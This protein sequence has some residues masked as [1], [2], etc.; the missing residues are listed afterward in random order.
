VRP[1]TDFAKEALFNVLNNLIGF[2]SVRVLDLFTGTGSIS[3][4]FVSR[5]CPSVTAVDRDPRCIGFINKVSLEFGIENLRTVRSDVFQILR[6]PAASF[7]LIFADPPY[8][9][10]GIGIIPDLIF[11]SSIL[12]PDGIFILEHP[13]AWNFEDNPHFSQKRTYGKVNFTFFGCSK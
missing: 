2:E 6:H 8:N 3:L 1:T 11:S 13:G 5:G 12:N 9:L 7:D 4:E 10:A